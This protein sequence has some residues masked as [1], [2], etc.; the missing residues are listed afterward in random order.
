MKRAVPVLLICLCNVLI[1]LHFAKAADTIWE[2]SFYCSYDADT[3]ENYRYAQQAIDFEDVH[4][5]LLNAAI[6]Y[7]TNRMRINHRKSPFIHAQPL[8]E[9]AFMHARDM[10]RAGFFSHQNPYEPKKRTL[11]QRLAMFG[12][13]GGYRAENIS[14]MFGILYEQGT[15]LIPPDRESNVFRDYGTGKPIPRHTYLSFAETLLDGWMKS[16]GHRANILNTNLRYL[17]CGAYHYRNES[18]YG[19]DQ[20]KAVQN[21]ASVV[22][23]K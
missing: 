11:S 23:D 8:E 16:K 13:E 19:M 6:F 17:G 21:F 7:A 9:A 4:Y 1:I 20:F 14:E 12:V 22:A 3:F 10:V 18:F 2:E 15:M 5:P